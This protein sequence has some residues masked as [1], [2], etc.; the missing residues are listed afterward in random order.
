[1][2]SVV[3]ILPNKFVF[4]RVKYYNNLQQLR[5]DIL[6]FTR[7]IEIDTS[8]LMETI[9]TEIQLTPE[10]I[11]SSPICNETDTNIY[12]ICYAGEKEQT[13]NENKIPSNPNNIGNYLINDTIENNCLLINSKVGNEK[14]CVPDSADIDTLVKLLYQKFFHIGIVIKADMSCPIEEFVYGDHPL[15]YY[16]VS[17]Y[18]E[19]KYKITEFNF[20][21][22][23][24][25]AVIDL[26]P[27]NNVINKRMT[28]IIGK[29]IIYG[30]VLLIMKIPDAYQ[31]LDLDLYKKINML[32]Y[33]PL[34]NRVL[35]E[36]E[37]KDTEKLNELHIINNKYSILNSRI[38]SLVKNYGNSCAYEG[39]KKVSDVL[40]LCKSCYRV[41]Y[42]DKECQ[43]L[44]WDTHKD[45]CFHKK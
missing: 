7:V 27:E 8:E 28:R 10:L 6:E 31:D 15:E 5:T 12:Q 39:C 9:I 33:G 16:K 36:E 37:T 35:T 42:H 44:G 22:L 45:E 25:C 17:A 14:T 18:D 32:S 40:S 38:N 23:G 20:V 29:E 19:N 21:S 11:G 13:L 41:K 43:T 30:D 24:L 1:M 26:L 34:I 4:D 3:T 2:I